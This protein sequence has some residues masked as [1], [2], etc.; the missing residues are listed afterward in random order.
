MI[1]YLNGA[2]V[3]AI[4]PDKWAVVEFPEHRKIFINRL[5]KEKTADRLTASVEIPGF[6][7]GAHS[8]SG[9]RRKQRGRSLGGGTVKK[10]WVNH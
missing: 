6:Q 9:V 1:S 5:V 4:K 2:A 8:V 3:E 10:T 7:D